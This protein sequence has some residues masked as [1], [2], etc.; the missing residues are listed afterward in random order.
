MQCSADHVW[1]GYTHLKGLQGTPRMAQAITLQGTGYKARIIVDLHISDT[2]RSPTGALKLIS[3]IYSV[4]DRETSKSWKLRGHSPR[5]L[6]DNVKFNV[7]QAGRASVLKKG[8]K[9]PHAYIDGV[10]E[11][12]AELG[13]NHEQTIA[14]MKARGAVYISY[15]PY[16]VEEFVVCDGEHL[17]SDCSNLKR[18]KSAET[19]YA[20]EHGCLA[21]L[22]E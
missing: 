5:L 3:R 7:S 18:I 15:D 1:W 11:N 13:L 6:I 12:H 9:T 17:P 16:K 19:V 20:Y 8:A 14:D 22:G 21:I 10:I 2:F 4:K